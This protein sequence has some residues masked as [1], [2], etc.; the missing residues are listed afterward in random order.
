MGTKSHRRFSLAA[1]VVV[2]AIILVVGG[3]LLLSRSQRLDAFHQAIKRGDVL[4]VKEF[5]TT[6]K[7][8][9]TEQIEGISVAERAIELH[10]PDVLREVLNMLPPCTPARSDGLP[11][12]HT[13]AWKGRPAEIAEIFRWCPESPLF[14]KGETPVAWAIRSGNEENVKFLRSLF[15]RRSVMLRI[16]SGFFMRNTYCRAV[17]ALGFALAQLR[18]HGTSYYG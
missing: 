1:A 8:L 14:W 6:D 2:C 7:S 3:Y 15:S 17:C 4:A 18:T 5:L 12:L 13:A 9:A 16:R 11:M 10:Q